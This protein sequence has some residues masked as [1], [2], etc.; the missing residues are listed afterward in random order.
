VKPGKTKPL[1]L[2]GA[3]AAGGLLVAIMFFAVGQ[4]S[5]AGGLL[6]PSPALAHAATGTLKSVAD[7]AERTLPSVVN[8]ST[9]RKQHA[10]A[11]PFFHDP[12]FREFFRHFGPR[13]PSPRMERSL[14]SGVI[15]SSDGVVVT[16]NHVVKDADKIRV[17]FGKREFVG[18]VVGT[19]PKSDLAVLKLKGARGL[20]AINFGD[21][22]KLRLG[23]MVVA[24]GNPFGVGQTVTMGIVSAKGRANV[25]IVDYEDF[26]QTDAAINPGNSGGALINMKGELVGI[27]TAILSRSGGYQGIGFAIPSNMVKPIIRSLLKKGRVVRGWLGV[28]IQ[29]VNRDLKRALGL[30]TTEGVLISDVDRQGPA[31]RAGL[32]RG[33]LLVRLN[34][35]KVTSTGRLRNLV[36][37]AGVGAKVNLEYFRNNKPHTVQVKLAE[38]PARLGGTRS[39]GGHGAVKPGKELGLSVAPLT[40]AIR[41]KYNIPPRLKTGVVVTGVDPTGETARTGLRSGDVIL[42]VNRARI[43][44]VRR[45]SQILRAARGDILFLVYRQGTTL[46][47]IVDR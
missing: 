7:V 14:G 11:S 17:T 39:G 44:T 12:F 37:S 16:N 38:L 18:K 30:H 26:I 41:R 15:I 24:I 3:G 29:E 42:E 36:A 27:N 4:R 5:S 33:D 20:R 43:D 22:D 21:S 47:M 23:D 1:A 32:R 2:V 31:R 35:R 9:T 19:D 25:G 34:G 46:Y 28:S 40:P 45:F 8:I 10:S 13:T 6:L